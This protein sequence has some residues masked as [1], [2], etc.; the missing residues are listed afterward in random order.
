MYHKVLKRIFL[1]DPKKA[2]DPVTPAS[3]MKDF[4][5]AIV[6]SSFELDEKTKSAVDCF[7]EKLFRY[8]ERDISFRKEQGILD[9]TVE[10]IKLMQV[11]AG[12]VREDGSS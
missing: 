3:N 7:E 9:M 11:I 6:E 5:K 2:E 12:K 10:T 8:F 4:V 1:P